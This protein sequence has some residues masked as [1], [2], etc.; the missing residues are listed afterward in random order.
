MDPLNFIPLEVVTLQRLNRGRPAGFSF[1]I[2]E[3]QTIRITSHIMVMYEASIN[4]S[5]MPA[6]CHALKYNGSTTKSLIIISDHCGKKPPLIARRRCYLLL[7]T[8]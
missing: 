7:K 3:N 4:G 8:D 6:I 1:S 5:P 2:P